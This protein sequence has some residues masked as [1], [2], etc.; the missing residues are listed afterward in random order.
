MI[1][2]IEMKTNEAINILERHNEWRRG[3]D[4]PMTEPKILGE[5]IDSAVD[6]LK[7]HDAE[8]EKPEPDTEILAEVEGYK[9]VRYVVVKWDGKYWTHHLPKIVQAMP[10]STEMQTT[11]VCHCHHNQ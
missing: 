11:F 8:T 2:T 10:H 4:V 6:A 1:R 7:W 3:A 9:T 5:A